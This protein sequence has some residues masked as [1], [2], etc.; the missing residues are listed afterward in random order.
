MGGTAEEMKSVIQ[1][2]KECF[3]CGKTTELHDHHIFHGTANR[4][5]AEQ[6]GM[7][8][9]LC[10]EHH[11]ELHDKSPEMDLTLKIIAQKHFE[12]HI[13][14]RDLFRKEFGKSYL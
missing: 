7:K 12:A 4:K 11:M 10:C 8:C 5:K 13:G 3:F 1:T 9:W 2:K 6:Y 14:D